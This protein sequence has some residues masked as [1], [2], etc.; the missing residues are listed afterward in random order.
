MWSPA[1]CTTVGSTGGRSG[2]DRAIGS[3]GE[4]PQWV[5]TLT[6]S[7]FTTS[8]K[9]VRENSRVSVQNLNYTRQLLFFFSQRSQRTIS[10]SSVIAGQ[11]TKKF[12]F[13]VCVYSST[14]ERCPFF[15]FQVSPLRSQ[16][17][18]FIS[19]DVLLLIAQFVPEEGRFTFLFTMHKVCIMD[20]IVH[21]VFQCTYSLE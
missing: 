4:G 15:T 18:R 17:Y 8:P 11:Y 21:D 16:L 13:H 2:W 9:W 20:Y 10:S 1:A 7:G 3:R 12:D 6:T 14:T 5:G 19:L